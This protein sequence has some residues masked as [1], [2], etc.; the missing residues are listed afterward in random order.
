MRKVG[1]VD[2]ITNLSSLRLRTLLQQ[3]PIA[4]Q[5]KQIH[6]GV[7]MRRRSKVKT[8][9]YVAPVVSISGVF[10]LPVPLIF[11]P[12]LPKHQIHQY[13]FEK[14]ETN[15]YSHLHS[16]LVIDAQF[17]DNNI[18]GQKLS[19]VVEIVYQGSIDVEEYMLILDHI[20]TN[21]IVYFRDL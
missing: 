1:H 12:L 10:V 16:L 21:G 14:R 17:I 19:S 20:V 3:L 2:N 11:G 8:S 7:H 5:R 15:V 13:L 4:T 18:I 6:Q 9:S